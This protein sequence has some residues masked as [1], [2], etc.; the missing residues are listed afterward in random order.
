MRK[1]K[2]YVD[3]K[4]LPPPPPS[5]ETAELR[6]AALPHLLTVAEVADVLRTS[7]KVVYDLLQVGALRRCAV[8]VG[9]RVLVDSELLQAWIDEQRAK[10]LRPWPD[11]PKPPL[12]PIPPTVPRRRRS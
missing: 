7:P 9:R 12:P 3:T 6:E 2:V 11:R 5:Y 1:K 10:P 8:R 4:D